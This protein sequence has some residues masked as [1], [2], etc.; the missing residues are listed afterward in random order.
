MKGRGSMSIT[1]NAKQDC[2]YL[3]SNMNSSANNS[4]SLYGINL[5]DYASIKNGS[6]GKLVKAYYNESDSDNTKTSSTTTKR[7]EKEKETALKKEM[8]DIQNAASDMKDSASVLMQTGVKSVF[9]DG[10]MEKVYKAVSAFT[11]DY[12]NLMKES[13][14]S[15]AG[16]IV[17]G[18]NALANITENYES[19]LKEIGI[20]VD[21]KTN[22]L[23]L[24]K[25]TFMQTDL[26]IVKEVFNGRDSLSYQTATQAVSISNTAYSE[27]NTGSLYTGSGNYN[28]ISTGDMFN[29]IV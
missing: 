6:Y 24:N 27:S 4:N 13:L 7:E 17:R 23:S 8:T 26:S 29:T 12:N 14:A 16:S 11:E 22:Q 9:K 21:S 25:E 5:A 18:A 19:I 1:I 2:S 28:N 10:D 15:S 20:T 3:F